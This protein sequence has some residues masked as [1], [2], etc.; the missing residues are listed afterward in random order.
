[1]HTTIYKIDNQ[2]GPTVQHKELYFVI[3]FFNN[4]YRERTD[5]NIHIW[6]SLVSQTLKNLPT[7]WVT[8][9]QSLGWE[10]PLEKGTVPTPVFWP[11]KFH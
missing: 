10:D 9:V 3:I 4:L 5:L 11:G 8:W 2:Q 7:L 1:M 6:D